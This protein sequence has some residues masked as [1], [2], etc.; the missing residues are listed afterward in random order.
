MSTLKTYLT[1]NTEIKAVRWNT[2]G[3]HPLDN[4]E[5]V[6]L[7]TETN[8]TPDTVLTEGKVVR[9]FRHLNILGRTVCVEC[10][11]I[12][13]EH[14]MIGDDESALM[15]CPGDYIVTTVDGDTYPTRSTEFELT[16]RIKEDQ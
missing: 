1:G 14:G 12:M 13:D 9:R 7:G 6:T 8:G 4:S 3:D 2:N 10:G 11:Y 16:Y 5:T 15:V